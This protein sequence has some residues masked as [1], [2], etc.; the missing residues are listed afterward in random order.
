[1]WFS[2]PKHS[3]IH[4]CLQEKAPSLAWHSRCLAVL[5]PHLVPLLC[6][7]KHH[8][9]SVRN[10]FFLSFI[11]QGSLKTSA[12]SILSL[13]Q[14]LLTMCTPLHWTP[15]MGLWGR[16]VVSKSP[17]PLSEEKRTLRSRH[18]G[19]IKCAKIYQGGWPCERKWSRQI[20]MPTWPWGK[21]RGREAWV[22]VT[23]VR[24][25]P[26]SHPCEDPCVFPEHA[27]LCVPDVAVVGWEQTCGSWEWHRHRNGFHSSSA[28]PSV[29]CFP[30][31]ELHQKIFF[32][33]LPWVLSA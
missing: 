10:A 29:I 15:A 22:E 25:P 14:H 6:T 18:Q 21:E 7:P 16:L 31:M 9:N 5:Q 23:V 30:L 2:G 26:Q 24:T 8:A 3:T 28:T 33:H 17:K 27:C 19:R 4:C 32:S 1:M 20:L 13:S 11:L 12:F